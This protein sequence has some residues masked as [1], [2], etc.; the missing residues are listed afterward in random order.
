[1]QTLD[2]A[3][4]FGI[5]RIGKREAKQLLSC[6]TGYSI[7][8]IVLHALKPLSDEK[9]ARY[10]EFVRRRQNSEPL[11]YIVGQWDFMGLTFLTDSRAL[12]PRPETELLVEEAFAFTQ[13]FRNTPLRILD[14]CT[15]SGC[16]AVALERLCE[17]AEVFAVDI[18]PRALS[19]AQENADKNGSRIHF[20]ESDLLAGVPVGGGF[21]VIISNPPYITSGEMEA[22]DPT[23]KD[24]EPHLALHGGTD[25]L[26]IY[27]R[28]I[29]QCFA[30]LRSGGALFLEI[31]PPAVMDLMASAGF[32]NTHLRH[33]YAEKERIIRGEKCLTN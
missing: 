4:A 14:V 15:G 20:Y 30:A 32:E 8:G 23:V 5:E 18:C 1:M 31:G 21:D 11:Q 2:D 12:I 7:S 33:D 10:T 13:K 28:L 27:R 6:A 16:I 22:L 25:G 9:Y 26:D 29:P 17:D 24:H 19:L 3:L